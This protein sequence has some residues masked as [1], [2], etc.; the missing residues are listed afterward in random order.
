MN[1]KALNMI[2]KLKEWEEESEKQKFAELLSTRRRI[3]ERIAEIE[4]RFNFLSLEIQNQNEISQQQL[5]TIYSEIEYLLEQKDNLVGLLEQIEKEIEAQRA[6]YENAFK[7]RKKTETI[8]ERVLTLEKFEKEKTE[9][10]EIA[11]ILM[12]RYRS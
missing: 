7:E 2:L 5:N 9:E 12:S 6:L 3:I 8:Y 4:R 1:K 10:K 11:D